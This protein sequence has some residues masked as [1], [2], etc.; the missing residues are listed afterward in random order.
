MEL[1][2][3]CQSCDTLGVHATLSVFRTHMLGKNSDRPVGEAQPLVWYP[4]A[5]H[6][7]SETVD[8][9]GFVIPQAAHT[10][11]VL[12]FKPYWIWGFEMGANDRGVV[13]GNEAEFSRDFGKEPSE[14]LLGMDLLRLGLERGATA[15]EALDVI[16]ALLERYGQNHNASA[17]KDRRYENSFLIM[18]EKE[19]WVLE[20]AGRRWCAKRVSTFHALGN[21]Y[22]LGDD[23]ELSSSDLEVHARE[24]GWLLPYEP[25]SFEK[26]YSAPIPYFGL[27]TPRNRR[28]RKLAAETPAHSFATMKRIFRDHHEGE[29]TGPRWG[30]T[31]GVFQSVCMHSMSLESAQTAASMLAAYKPGLGLTMRAAF[32][33]PCGSL[34]LPVYPGFTQPEPLSRGEGV[35]DGASLWWLMDR[36]AKTICIDPERFAPAVRA[37]IVTIEEGF[38]RRAEEAEAKAAQQFAVGDAYGAHQTLYALTVECAGVAAKFATENWQRIREE[39]HALGVTTLSGSHADFLRAYCELT[40]MELL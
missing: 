23:F 18:D 29:L 13:I 19:L 22:S 37:Q 3:D 14:G 21:T 32:S 10:F 4:A 20:T 8:C 24:N 1:F 40:K 12:G 35:F 39:L 25:F 31:S 30:D 38:E 34:Y 36:L 6:E 16:A 2:Q 5:D 7:N 15:R 11:G 9:S 27:T 28:V 26:A 33:Q 17:L